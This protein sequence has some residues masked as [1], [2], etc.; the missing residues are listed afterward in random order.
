MLTGS[1]TL[2]A[3]LSKLS[4]SGPHPC[5]CEGHRECFKRLVAKGA[6][7]VISCIVPVRLAHLP[8]LTHLSFN[9]LPPQLPNLAPFFPNLTHLGIDHIPLQPHHFAPVPTFLADLALTLPSTL[10]HFATRSPLPAEVCACL[11]DRLEHLSTYLTWNYQLVPVRERWVA[12]SGIL[13][14]A[15]GSLTI[16][17]VRDLTHRETLEAARER[18]AGGEEVAA[19]R[20]AGYAVRIE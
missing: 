13:S 10:T 1:S 5:G 7:L 6:S 15:L 20:R 14:C 11:P 12:Q 4:I 18:L 19:L 8:A 2:L 3:G 17:A 9:Y 16:V